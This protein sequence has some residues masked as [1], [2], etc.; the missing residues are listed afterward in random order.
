MGTHG[1][2]AYSMHHPR[3]N[4]RPLEEWIMV[5]LYLYH[6]ENTPYIKIQKGDMLRMPTLATRRA[7]ENNTTSHNQVLEPLAPSHPQDPHQ[8]SIFFCGGGNSRLF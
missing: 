5:S 2:R 1:Q 4:G 3:K 7:I 8:A 6:S